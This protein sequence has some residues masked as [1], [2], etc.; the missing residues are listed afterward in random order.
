[1]LLVTGAGGFIGRQVCQLLS[2]SGQDI[3]A[4]DRDFTPPLPINCLQGDLTND[5]FLS[6]LFRA[7]SFEAIIHLAG[8]LNTASRLQPQEAMRVNIGCSLSLLQLAIQFNVTKFI[9]GSSISAYGAKPFA[10]FGEVS[11]A[12]PASPG[13]VYGASKRF[14]E[15]VGENLR[16]QDA[17]QFIALRISMVV[18]AG[19]ANTSSP[20]R[21][22]IFERLN[23]PQYT[24]INLPFARNERLPLVHVADVAEIIKRLSDAERSLH[25]V[26]NTPSDNW[27]CADLADV[28]QSLNRN[29]ELAFSPTGVRGDPEA[30]DGSRFIGEFGFRPIPLHERLGR[31]I[32]N[33]Q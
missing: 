3:L 12:E 21:S 25:P 9:Y 7:H 16:K 26:Y 29:V 4:I 33:S 24:V 18:G 6:G 28:I 8:L 10:E 30:I 11:E 20:W 32:E 1:M 23:S 5:D 17:I 2:A 31:V 13:N 19:A 15:I 27:L 22:E 14:V